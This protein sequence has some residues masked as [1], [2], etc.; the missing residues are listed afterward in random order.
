MDSADILLLYKVRVVSLDILERIKEAFDKN[1]ITIPY[2]Q[3]TIRM[4][5]ATAGA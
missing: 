4:V 1:G 3:R 5:A 2:P